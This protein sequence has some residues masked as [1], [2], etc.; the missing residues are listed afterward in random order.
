MNKRELIYKIYIELV[1]YKFKVK[2]Y[3]IGLTINIKNDCGGNW[4]RFI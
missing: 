1:K 2:N 4:Q 3:Y